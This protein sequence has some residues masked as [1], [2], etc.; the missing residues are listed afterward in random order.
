MAGP[1]RRWTDMTTEDF[2]EGDVASWIAAL[3]VAAVEQHG[4]HLPL[5]VDVMLG[6]GYLERALALAPDDLPVTA[7]PTQAV[8]LSPEHLAFPGTLTLSPETVIRA[9]TEI[10]ASVARAGVRKI[11]FINSHGGNSA[12]LDVVAR[13]LR[14]E[15]GML[16][17]VTSWHRLGYPDGLFSA[18]ELRNGI[19]GGEIETSV[20]LKLRPDLVRRDR[21][22]DFRSA[23][24]GMERDYA[25]LRTSTPAG[26]GWMSQDL[27]PS[28]AIGN[29]AAATSAKG[30]AALAHGAAAFIEL[31][32]DMHR[33]PVDSLGTA[34]GAP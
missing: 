21:A 3:P 32:R 20:M 1:R 9:W 5:G 10:G 26:F 16:A 14:V 27:H 29:A 30:E 23:A 4:P 33:F 25:R 7:L 22:D 24:Y 17:V 34:A 13:A 2:R 18:E 28:G 31:L 8:G 19:H 6:E 12:V 11:L 15:H